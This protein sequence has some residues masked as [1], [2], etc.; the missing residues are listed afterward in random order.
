VAAK[1]LRYRA[2]PPSSQPIERH[3]PTVGEAPP[4]ECP[5]AI[6]ETIV[7]SGPDPGNVRLRRKRARDKIGAQYACSDLPPLVCHYLMSALNVTV[8]PDLSPNEARKVWGQLATALLL[9]HAQQ[10]NS[11]Q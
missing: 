4:V 9:A 1:M 5:A 2:N 11:R 8:P 7:G 10:W 3:A 6:I